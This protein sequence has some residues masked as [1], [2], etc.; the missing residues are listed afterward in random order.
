MRPVLS[1]ILLCYTHYFGVVN[2]S[3]ATEKKIAQRC[4]LATVASSDVVLVNTII[5]KESNWNGRAKN[6]K[7]GDYGIM[8]INLRY[9]P[10]CSPD[11]VYDIEYNIRNGYRIL[12]E[13]RKRNIP[14]NKVFYALNRR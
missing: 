4:V 8:Q 6:Q 7:T 5:E 2:F 9:H 12:I 3:Y 14:A 1:L 11:S 13:A 10:E